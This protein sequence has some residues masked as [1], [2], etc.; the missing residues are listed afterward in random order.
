MHCL[1]HGP[2]A[3]I[4]CSSFHVSIHWLVSFHLIFS[5]RLLSSFHSVAFAHLLALARLIFLVFVCLPIV[6]LFF[7]SLVLWFQHGDLN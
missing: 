7:V 4:S 1:T 5:A 6:A 3:L 2:I